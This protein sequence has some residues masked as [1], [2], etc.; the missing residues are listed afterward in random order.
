MA[1][2]LL[3]MAANVVACHDVPP[4]FEAV[5]I[6]MAHSFPAMVLFLGAKQRPRGGPQ[7]RSSDNKVFNDGAVEVMG[8]ERRNGFGEGT[9]SAIVFCV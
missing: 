7:R 1:S 2:N 8:E 3:A 5:I 9:A 6:S 4:Y